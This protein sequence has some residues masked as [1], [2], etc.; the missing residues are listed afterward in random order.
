MLDENEWKSEYH[1]R[2]LL[3]YIV[4][5]VVNLNYDG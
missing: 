1:M 2:V 3:K 5:R 4:F